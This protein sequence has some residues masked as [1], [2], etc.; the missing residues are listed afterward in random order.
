MNCLFAMCSII[1]SLLPL[2]AQN[3]TSTTEMERQIF[4][5]TNQEREKANVP[6]LKWNG[7]L[8]IAARIHSD[9]MAK[10]GQL[11]HQ[12]PNEPTFTQRISDRGARFSAAA[13]N[14]GFADDAET[15][16]SGWM[17][18]PGHRANILNPIYDEIGIGIVRKGD[19]FYATE[20]FAKAVQNLSA[21]DFE[22]GVVGEI[23]RI[24]KQRGLAQLRATHSA[25]LER[26]ACSGET[27]AGAAFGAVNHPGSAEMRAFN[28]TAQSANQ[29]PSDLKQRALDLPTGAFTIGACST[30]DPAKGFS[31][32]R[33]LMVL[34]R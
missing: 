28:F 10:Q 20:D 18:S 7:R 27:S 9:E 6:A 4:D 17:H 31:G 13:E 21:Q 11:S 19:R 30:S 26:M 16:Q 32:Y 8:A 24:R 1:L 5:W 23:A 12:L 2:H 22:D 29:L 25:S 34:Y 3:V 14:V 15:L 33:V